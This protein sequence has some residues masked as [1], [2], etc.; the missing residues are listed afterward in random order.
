MT[1]LS[2]FVDENNLLVFHNGVELASV[3][4]YETCDRS[5]LSIFSALIPGE[6]IILKEGTFL[7]DEDLDLISMFHVFVKY[8]GGW[9]G[10]DLINKNGVYE[11]NNRE[12]QGEKIFFIIKDGYV[13]KC[14]DIEEIKI[15]ENDPKRIKI[16]G[17]IIS[18]E[19]N[20]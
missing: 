17:E 13:V 12:Y 16:A 14:D 4:Q 7:L 9:L 8:D 6:K 10:Y 3:E 18:P 20:I 5:D 1:T 15:Y 11:F 19:V 2:I